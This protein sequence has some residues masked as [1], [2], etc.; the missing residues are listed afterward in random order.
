MLKF[1]RKKKRKCRNSLFLI[2]RKFPSRVFH[3]KKKFLLAFFS[4]KGHVQFF[5]E[6]PF[7]WRSEQYLSFS[8]PPL[9]L[10]TSA[11]DATR[12]M[13]QIAV[14]LQSTFLLHSGLFRLSIPMEYS[15]IDRK[16]T[17]LNSSHSSVSRM[18]SS[19]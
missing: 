6:C 16:S 12:H 11:D 18:P 17:R 15:T 4:H 8:L 10:Q 9:P 19:A 2:N 7:R 1:K 5:L 13:D 3:E 14:R